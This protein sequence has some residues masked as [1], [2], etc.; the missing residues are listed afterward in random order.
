M[1]M[2]SETFVLRRAEWN[3]DDDDL[4]KNKSGT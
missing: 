1:F 3:N 4:K 2:K